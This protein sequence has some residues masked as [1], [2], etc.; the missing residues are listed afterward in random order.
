MCSRIVHQTYIEQFEGFSL[1]H[2][3]VGWSLTCGLSI[4]DPLGLI[5]IWMRA[6]YERMALPV[7]PRVSSWRSDGTSSVLGTSLPMPF[8]HVCRCQ[9][10]V[11]FTLCILSSSF[12]WCISPFRQPPEVSCIPNSIVLSFFQLY[13][14]LLPIAISLSSHLL[15]QM[16][17]CKA[18]KFVTGDARSSRTHNLLPLFRGLWGSLEVSNDDALWPGSCENS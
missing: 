7:T 15:P 3:A 6:H 18:S 9:R 11:L 8:S 13:C 16:A 12:L 17:S 14:C 4:L 2:R 5:V 1:S 10:H